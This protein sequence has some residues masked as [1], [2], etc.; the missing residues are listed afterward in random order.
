MPTPRRVARIAQVLHRRQPEIVL[1]LDGVHDPHNLSAILRSADA[2]GL[3]RILWQPDREEPDPPNPEVALGTER[4]VSL[5]AVP[6]L[7]EA[8]LPLKAG[9]FRVAATH[10]AADAVDF[11]QV[12]WTGHWVV[13]L[14]NEHRGCT[15]EILV[16][17]DTNIVLPM[18]GFVQ[19]LNVSVAAAV[20][21]Y[22]IQ[23]QREA[24]GLYRRTL[25]EGTVRELYER[26]HL[27]SD[28]VDLADLREPPTGIPEG[29]GGHTDGR[30]RGQG[31]LKRKPGER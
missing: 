3:T 23:R 24:A 16:V 21:L 18:M 9:G 8:I 28:G 30:N 22:E 12:D 4:W 27:A 15:D 26:W 25:P 1:A 29:D 13:V 5:D 10:L 6:N 17:T 2:T 7:R 19:S 11:R 31:R 20:L 14:G